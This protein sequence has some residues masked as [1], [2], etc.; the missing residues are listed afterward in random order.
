MGRIDTA[1]TVSQLFGRERDIFQNKNGQ[2]K[3][4]LPPIARNPLK[5]LVSVERMAII[6]LT[7]AALWL[8]WNRV[9][10]RRSS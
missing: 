4:I 8:V 7:N 10:G 5:R 6:N 1:L 3:F 2:C 9:T